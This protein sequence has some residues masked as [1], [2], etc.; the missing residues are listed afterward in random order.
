MSTTANGGGKQ[1]R[2]KEVKISPAM[3]REWLAV[4]PER[5]QRAIRQRNVGKILHA[6][7]TGEWKMTHQAIALDPT[8]FVLDG[9]HR[10]TAIAA[11]RK[12]VVA[13]V[14]YD[15]DPETFGVIDVGAARSPG[16]SLKIAG[17]KD[18]NVLSAVTRQVLAYPEV[19]GTTTTLGTVT[20]TVT[21]ADLLIALDKPEI[22]SVI[23]AS[24][25]PGHLAAAEIGRY[26]MRTSIS[27]LVSV[28]GLYSK[29]GPESQTEFWQHLASGADLAAGSPILAM[30]RWLISESGYKKIQ[31]T[32]R[33][34][35]F[36]AN[37]I[38][39][40]NDFQAGR[41][42]SQLKYRPG[43]DHMPEVD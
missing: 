31:P 28:I 6:I 33:P 27:T 7:E 34:T 39:A 17:Y 16:D 37:G 15:A 2:L 5:N 43:V 13:L 11:Q 12:H 41:R 25:R 30:R 19:I 10:L 23:E 22:G 35:T 14:A 4:S 29:A 38:K 32:Y 20:A 18:V 3:A 8:G 24:I 26:G 40:W 21:T 42:R 9:R 36:L 1:M